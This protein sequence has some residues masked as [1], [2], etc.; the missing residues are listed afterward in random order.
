MRFASLGS[1]SEGNGLVVESPGA[2][3]TRV[4][5]D[6][7]FTIKECERRLARLGLLAESLSAVV[8]THE[9]G[10]HISGVFKLARR[11]HLPVWLTHG[12]LAAVD[13]REVDGVTFHCCTPGF[14]F[15]IAGVQVLPYA[16]PHDAR[17]PVQYVF[18]DGARRLA[19]LTDAG[20]ATAHIVDMLGGCHTLVLECN[21]D[22]ELLRNSS[23]PPSLKTRIGGA[24]GHLANDVAAQIL[25]RIDRSSLTRVIA[26]HLSR[27]N[28]T[29][30]LARAAL[31]QVLSCDE[32]EILV[33]D[34]E[35][36]L[37]WME[38]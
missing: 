20:S 9:H 15:S 5:L 2:R 3:P 10:D 16:V 27:S 25:Q 13:R 26:A 18:S 36:G 38:V 1:G 37:G 30:G 34:Q 19:V 23:Y 14:G 11:Y 6:C 12:T 33:A 28:N 24:Y 8:V 29:P 22:S 7:G 31:A 32:E 4:L 35:L 21:H 17:E